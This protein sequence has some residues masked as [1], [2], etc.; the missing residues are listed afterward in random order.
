MTR[1]RPRPKAHSKPKIRRQESWRY[2]RLSESWRKPRGKT[3]RMRIRRKGWPAIATIGYKGPREYRMV[4]PSGLREKLIY[5]PEELTGL[6]PDKE[7]VRIAATVGE[8]KRVAIVDQAQQLGL[9]ILN[10]RAP[11]A[12]AEAPTL[13]EET[14]EIA[15]TPQP[16]K[17]E[18]ETEESKSETVNKE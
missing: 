9:R 4:H 16:I 12:E 5:R 18:E 13:K 2:T 6:S 1:D 3:S 7:V 15:E 17:T 11:K 14:A 10:P 8:R